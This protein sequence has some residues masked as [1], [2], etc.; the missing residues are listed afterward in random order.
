MRAGKNTYIEA[1]R[2]MIYF[3][4]FAE[5]QQVDKFNLKNIKLHHVEENEFLFYFEVNKSF[6][7][8]IVLV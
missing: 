2:T 1:F 4:E 8:C 7:G 5:Q 6:F 3:E